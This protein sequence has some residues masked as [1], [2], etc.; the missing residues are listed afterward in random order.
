MLEVEDNG[1][2]IA[3]EERE[4]VFERFYRVLGGS[5]SDASAE[6][7]GLGLAIVREIAVQHH[8]Q[9]RIRDGVQGRGTVFAVEFALA[10]SAARSANAHAMTDGGRGK[11]GT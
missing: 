10:E 3:R 4:L 8:A 2:G 9:V 5:A 1:I 6:G 7:S 11:L